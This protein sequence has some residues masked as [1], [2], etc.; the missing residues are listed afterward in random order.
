MTSP[1][2]LSLLAFAILSSG[3]CAGGGTGAAPSD[4]C[5]NDLGNGEEVIAGPAMPSDPFGD[6][7]FRSLCVD[8]NDADTIYLGTEENGLVRSTDGG[9]TWQRLR[10]GMRHSGTA[11]PEIRDVAVSPFDANRIIVATS[12]SPGP[13]TGS[14]PSAIAGFYHS[15]DG[16]LQLE[17]GNCGLPSGAVSALAFDPTDATRVL[18]FV[19]G[20]RATFTPRVGEFFAGGIFDSADFGTTWGAVSAPPGSDKNVYWVVATSTNELFTFGIGHESGVSNLGFLRS[21]DGGRTWTTFAASQRAK[22][23]SEFDVSQDGMTIVANE[24]DTFVMLRSVDG[25][26]TWDTLS[27]GGNGPVAVSPADPDIVLYDDNGTLRRSTDRLASVNVV[28]GSGRRFDDVEFA[29]SNPQVVYAATE[30]YDLWCS[31]D[32]GATWTFRIN[33]RSAGVLD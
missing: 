33:L 29:P 12:D 27:I 11:Y 15:R 23:I 6:Q 2:L 20:G 1:L 16:G 17:R 14:V 4:P 13:I 30:G 31:T 32:A 22:L 25:G 21:A 9:V 26:V 8:P 3:G 5:G 7:V 19:S 10:R 18:A 24:R 28:L